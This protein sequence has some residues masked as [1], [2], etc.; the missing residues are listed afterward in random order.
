M[1]KANPPEGFKTK[2]TSPKS[3]ERLADALRENLLRRKAQ[4][5]ARLSEDLKGAGLSRAKVKK[6]P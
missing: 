3:Q 2:P 1:V 4:K 6:P 5:R